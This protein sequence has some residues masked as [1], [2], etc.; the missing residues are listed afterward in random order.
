MKIGFVLPMPTTKIV[1]G[2]KVVYEYAN[3]LAQKGNDVT[4]FY[5]SEKG[6]NSKSLPPFLVYSL[7][8]LISFREPSWFDLLPDV[9]KVNLYSLKSRYFKGYDTVIATAAETAVFVNKLSVKNKIYLIQDFEKNWQLA[10]DQLFE[11]YN[12]P[13]MTLITVSK[14]LVKKVSE[15]TNKKIYYI[16]NGI[17]EKVFKN[18]G[19]PRKKHSIAMLYHLDQRKGADI[20]LRVIF[21][22]KQK[23]PDLE[24]NLFGTPKRDTNWPEW[25]NYTRFAKP[26]QV[27]NIM[28]NSNVF[29]CTSRFEGFG[30]TGLE[31]L[32]CGCSFVTTDCG[33][34]REYASENNATI[35]KIDDVEGLTEGVCKEYEHLYEKDNKN[36][37]ATFSLT[38]ATKKFAK[39]VQ[40]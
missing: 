32:F 21:K 13:N 25:I 38:S 3:Y 12:Y 10:E 8:Q 17:D 39:L 5:N 16:P 26:K 31:S 30:L 7:R 14:W 28:N 6:R 15:H 24:A 36:L 1:G 11:T 4:I 22:L 34:V 27:A 19:H 40:N 2:Y 35:C 33:G 20:G 37:Y 18:Y 9:R 23:Y 29:L